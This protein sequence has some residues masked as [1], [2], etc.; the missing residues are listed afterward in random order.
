MAG[1]VLPWLIVGLVVLAG[2]KPKPEPLGVEAS[3]LV[4]ILA[5][6]HLAEG[7]MELVNMADRDTLGKRLYKSILD[8]HGV[9]REVFDQTMLVLREDPQRLE[10]IYIQVQDR[11]SVIEAKYPDK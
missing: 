4:D 7:Q 8:A 10:A 6:I 3:K 1:K 2:C 11:L 5:E 9:Q